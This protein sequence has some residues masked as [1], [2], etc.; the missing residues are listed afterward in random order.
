MGSPVC[1][2]NERYFDLNLHVWQY[3]T[4][5]LLIL[6]GYLKINIFETSKAGVFAI[7]KK[8]TIG[9]SGLRISWYNANESREKQKE[10]HNF[11]C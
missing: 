6:Q 4:V 9:N 7:E 3:M 5:C 2:Q 8:D 10:I 11:V 1:Q